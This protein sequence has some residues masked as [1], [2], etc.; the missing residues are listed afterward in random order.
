MVRWDYQERYLA[1]DP[2]LRAQQFKVLGEEG[3]QI[4]N[5]WVATPRSDQLVCKLKFPVIVE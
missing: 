2:E 1:K 4:V 3:V 5:V